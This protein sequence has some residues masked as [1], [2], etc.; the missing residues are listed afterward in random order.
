[1]STPGATI[2]IYYHHRYSTVCR[3]GVSSCYSLPGGV[4]SSQ[5]SDEQS[6]LSNRSSLH[7]GLQPL[8]T[9][10]IH[11]KRILSDAT[12][13]YRRCRRSY[14]TCSYVEYLVLV[15]LCHA[16][17]SWLLWLPSSHLC[18]ISTNQWDKM[19]TPYAKAI[20]TWNI[21]QKVIMGPSID[22]G[23]NGTGNTNRK[24][25]AQ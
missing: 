6:S 24:C 23:G 19:N 21:M 15:L 20:F 16:T 3:S 10:H 11:T 9:T 25:V 4:L 1:M 13:V 7:L 22:I 18:F 12:Q 14:N 2:I 8:S 5:S 17:W